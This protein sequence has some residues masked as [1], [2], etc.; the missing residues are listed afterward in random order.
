MTQRTNYQRQI[1]INAILCLCIGR[2][3]AEEATPGYAMI[4]QI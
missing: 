1:V 3:Y 2:Q 4:A